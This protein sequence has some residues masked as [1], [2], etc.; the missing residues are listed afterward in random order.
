MCICNFSCG[1]PP[2]PSSNTWKDTRE[3]RGG[4]HYLLGVS[5]THRYNTPRGSQEKRLHNQQLA[6]WYVLR[7]SFLTST[8]SGSHFLGACSSLRLRITRIT[9]LIIYRRHR[10][11]RDRGISKRFIVRKG[12]KFLTRSSN[13]IRTSI[14]N[15][16]NIL[17]CFINL[18][19]FDVFH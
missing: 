2:P 8:S 13:P 16:V 4:L 12:K 9:R 7:D 17:T 11:T 5:S 19:C 18:M 3:I 1:R 14:F 15:R 6:G 10:Y